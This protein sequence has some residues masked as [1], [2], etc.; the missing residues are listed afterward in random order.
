MA[1]LHAPQNPIQND[2]VAE[3]LTFDVM[4]HQPNIPSQFL[5]PDHELQSLTSPELEVP[6]IDLKAF[7]SGDPKAIE[8]ACLQ[9]SEACKKHGFF[10]IVNHG[11]DGKLK[12]EALNLLDDFFCMPLSEK[13]RAKRKVGEHEG[14][15]NSFIGRFSSN[16][17]WKETLSFF[18]ST[19]SS[20]QSVED[21]FVKVLGEDFRKFGNM[22]QDY[23]EAMNNISFVVM[24]ILGLSLGVSREYFRDFF[25]GAKSIM[26]LN[27][28]PPCQKPD[29]VLGTGPH[30]DPPALAILNQDQV[31]GLQVLVDGTWYSIVPKEDAFVVNL[32]DTFMALSNGI[33]KSCL[34]RALVNDKIVRKSIA[35]FLCTN[36][37]KVV[38][39]PKELINKEN[40]RL[41]PDFNWPTFHEFT[42]KHYRCNP[43]TLDAFSNW[44]KEEELITGNPNVAT[45]IKYIK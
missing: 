45:A 26:R 4:Q 27:Y 36:A 38:T 11:V 17:P 3:K 30:C 21:Y 39:P 31:G 8:T 18:Y 10:H 28:Y 24:E 42:Q 29:L 15:A 32:G 35:F 13:E 6:T 2:K 23:S 9:V 40:P 25:E 34:H 43:K 20:V 41:Y 7:L 16:L 22:Y 37:E 33:Y 14:Y 5:W 12:S 19:D 44:V 1:M